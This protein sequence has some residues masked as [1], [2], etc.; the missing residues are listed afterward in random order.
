MVIALTWG[1]SP[2]LLSR[3]V[4]AHAAKES[5]FDTHFL[6]D[7][8][9]RSWLIPARSGGRADFTSLAQALGSGWDSLPEDAA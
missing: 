9:V 1:M 5:A 7:V 4:G 8:S 3:M 6:E 2:G